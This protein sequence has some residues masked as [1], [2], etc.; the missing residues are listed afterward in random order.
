MGYFNGK[1]RKK[2]IVIF[3]FD[4][5]KFDKKKGIVVHFL[6]AIQAYLREASISKA[7]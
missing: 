5:T 1:S 7:L 4:I 3:Q 2:K 6:F